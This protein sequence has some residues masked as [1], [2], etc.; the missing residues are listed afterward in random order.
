VIEVRDVAPFSKAFNTGTARIA[1]D[2]FVQVDAD[3]VLDPTCIEHLRSCMRDGVGLVLGSLRDA[4]MGRVGWIKLFRRACCDAVPH[5][6]VITTDVTFASEI[7]RRGWSIVYAIKP[8][9]GADPELWHTLGEHSPDYTPLYTLT[10]HMRG[11]RRYRADRNTHG[12]AW[13]IRKLAASRHRSAL[14]AQV[15]LALGIF[16]RAGNDLYTPCERTPEFSF[17][18]EFSANTATPPIRAAMLVPWYRWQPRAT[19]LAGVRL[20]NKLRDRAA[21]PAFE[22]CM[23]ILSC[24]SDPLAWVALVGLCRGAFEPVFAPRSCLEDY[25]LLNELLEGTRLRDIALERFRGVR[26]ALGRAVRAAL[27]A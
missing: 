15:G 24:S 7:V 4:L 26:S 2:F 19:F 23:A 13:H 18:E 1:T 10:K 6:D 12:L 5:P 17:W 21:F 3:M 25:V 9:P 16:I 22:R 11:G 20:G 8:E 14:I 27:P